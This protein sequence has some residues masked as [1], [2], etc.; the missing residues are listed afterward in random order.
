MKRTRSGSTS[1]RTHQENAPVWGTKTAR[2]YAF[3]RDVASNDDEAFVA[4]SPSSAFTTDALI[5][6]R[7]FGIGIV[8]RVLGSKIEVLFED[9]TRTLGHDPTGAAPAKPDRVTPINV[10]RGVRWRFDRKSYASPEEFAA[11]VIE[12]QRRLGRP[13]ESLRFRPSALAVRVR[14]IVLGFEYA[15]PAESAYREAQMT[16]ES[17]DPAGFRQGE[18]LWK[19]HQALSAYDLSDHCFFEGLYLG[20]GGERPVYCLLQGS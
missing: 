14:A 13:P 9:G 11:A 16:L 1:R 12:Y 8:T 15:D 20:E 18:L 17:S 19:I 4:Y 6:H 5:E 10:M 3:D 7:T 2:T